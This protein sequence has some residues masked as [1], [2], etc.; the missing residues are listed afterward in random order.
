MNLLQEYEQQQRWRD[1]QRYLKF[2]PWCE[3][4]SV[5]D[6][7]CSVGGVARLFSLRVKDV[8]GIDVNQEFIDFCE[9]NKRLNETFI[10][11]DFLEFMNRP[12]ESANG[13]WGSYSLSY[14]SNPLDFLCFLHSILQPGGWIA[15]LDVSCF[16]SGNLAQTSPF[17]EPVRRFELDSC[18]S[19]IYDFD[20]GS[21]MEGLLKRSE[22]EI[23]YVD[24]DVTDVELNFSGAAN[25][26]VIQ[27]WSARLERMQRLK[28]VLGEGYGEFCHDLLTELGSIHHKKQRNVRF[29]VA[30]KR[31]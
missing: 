6:L 25:K 19:G 21:K 16:I 31:R 18:S 24:N 12:P 30:K 17:Y 14:L 13:F 26:D 10:C 2:I 4:D 7:G 15:L 23:M 29:V 5:V 20:F 8:L 11:M 28:S 22:F 9:A 1:W 3:D 27:G